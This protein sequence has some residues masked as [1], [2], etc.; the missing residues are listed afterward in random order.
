MKVEKLTEE[1]KSKLSVY[2]DRY[3]NSILNN[4]D[5]V[6]VRV[7]E[8][9]FAWF[10][11]E[12]LNKKAP[13]VILSKNPYE[14]YVEIAKIENNTDDVSN[15]ELKWYAPTNYLSKY[16][17]SWIAFY[18]FF[19]KECFTLKKSKLFNDYKKLF[20]QN[21]SFVVAF[22]N[23]VFVSKNAIK[24][25]RNEQKQLHSITEKAVQFDGWGFYAI[26]GKRISEELFHKLSN[27]EYTFDDWTKEQDEEIKSVVLAF[28]EEK[29]GQE[30]LYSF[31]SDNLQEVDTYKDIK[32]EKYLEKTTKGMNVGVYT[33]FK[34]NV[35]N[36]DYS[37]VRCYCPSTDRMF[38]L[39]CDPKYNNAKDAIAS[40]YR[41]PE[42][43]IPYIK[44]IQRQGERFSTVLTD[45]G[46]EVRKKLSKEDIQNLGTVDGNTYFSKMKYEY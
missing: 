39:G 42:K 7:L 19:D 1:Q 38:F 13:K 45:E 23:Y 41:L 34:G 17:I 2:K 43:L 27:D 8:E 21:I 26:R 40:L 30:R 9:Y 22:E 12:F 14:M 10:Y 11:D 44:Y 46:K 4:T 16:W 15:I 25:V 31:L 24:Y 3:I 29:W 5:E 35:N 37:F 32:D 33:L 18:D 28:I 20:D 36:I 6:D